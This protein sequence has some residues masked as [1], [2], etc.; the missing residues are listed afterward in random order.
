M[1]VIFLLGAFI[2][3]ILVLVFG[4]LFHKVLVWMEREE[5]NLEL[6]NEVRKKIK[7]EIEERDVE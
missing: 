1:W 7:K 2:A 4:I 6:E 3:G 5:K